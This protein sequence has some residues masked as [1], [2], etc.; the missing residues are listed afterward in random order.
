MAKKD[1]WFRAK[2]YGWGW[3][4]ASWQGWLVIGI[5]ILI[6]FGLIRLNEVGFETEDPESVTNTFLPVVILTAILILVSYLKGE[7]PEWRW[8]GKPIRK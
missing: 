5:Y 3:Y 4:P 1:L 6:V 2:N 7:K 8:K